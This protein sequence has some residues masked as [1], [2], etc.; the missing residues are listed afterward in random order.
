MD[1]VVEVHG[2]C[3]FEA[4]ILR[5]LTSIMRALA[6]DILLQTPQYPVGVH[7]KRGITAGPADVVS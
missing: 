5:I 1:L 7:L 6:C 3:V 4:P 2:G